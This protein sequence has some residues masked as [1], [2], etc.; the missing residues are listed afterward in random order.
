MVPV[1]RIPSLLAAPR[2][3]ALLGRAPPCG[4]R[5]RG[6]APPLLLFG[7]PPPLPGGEGGGAAGH[8]AG[9]RLSDARACRARGGGTCAPFTRPTEG[10]A[11]Q[12]GAAARGFRGVELVAAHA[13]GEQ[14]HNAPVTDEGF[15]PRVAGA[16]AGAPF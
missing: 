12:E 6:E 15:P 9:V 5:E 8:A 11:T 4:A 14:T 10:R 3:G 16:S 2:R 13:I 1:L 7:K